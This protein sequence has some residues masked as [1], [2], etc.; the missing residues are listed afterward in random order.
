MANESLNRIWLV[1]RTRYLLGFRSYAFV[2][3]SVFSILH[4][5]KFP[6][7]QQ[8]TLPSHPNTDQFLRGVM[9]HGRPPQLTS[10]FS[11]LIR[12]E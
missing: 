12:D 10:E 11:Q 6:L 4:R 9:L 2:G 1:C 5:K 3:L 8:G 7:C